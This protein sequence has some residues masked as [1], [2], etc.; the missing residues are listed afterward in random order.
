[1]ELVFR[2][3]LCVWGDGGALHCNAVFAG[4]LRRVYSYLIVGLVAVRKSKVVIVR[5]QVYER[6]DEL[7][8]YH[9]PQNAGHLVTVH[10]HKRSRHLYLFHKR[11][12]IGDHATT[13]RGNATL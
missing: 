7:I 4:S 12:Y 9:L 1:M 11:F 2:H 8:L 6:K 13:A 10:L 5:L 3:A